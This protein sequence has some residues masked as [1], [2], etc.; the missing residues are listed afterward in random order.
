MTIR[1]ASRRHTT[2]LRARGVAFWEYDTPR[3]KTQDGVV[4]F[5]GMPSAWLKDSEDNIRSIGQHLAEQARVI[6]EA[7][8]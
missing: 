5:D 6:R 4:E 2:E 3:L 1:R 8:K 7:L